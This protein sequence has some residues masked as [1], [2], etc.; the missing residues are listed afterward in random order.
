MLKLMV[1]LRNMSTLDNLNDHA[2]FLDQSTAY[3]TIRNDTT[4]GRTC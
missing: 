3:S 4:E 2:M 1:D